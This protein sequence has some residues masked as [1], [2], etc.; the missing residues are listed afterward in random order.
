MAFELGVA[1]H[2]YD[3]RTA[4]RPVLERLAVAADDS[5]FLSL[6]SGDES[7]CIDL[8]PGPSPIRVVTLEIGTRRPLGAGAGGL[9]ILGA[10]PADER[11]DIL[12]R[13]APLLEQSWGLGKAALLASI[14]TFDEEGHAFIRNRVHAGIS[15][16]G[17]PVRGGFGQPIAAL[18]IAALNER[19]TAAR[20]PPLLAELRQAA[21][22]LQLQLD[23][24]P[25]RMP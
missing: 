3:L 18:S 20:I 19:L 22:A 11:A 8:Q 14:H 17:V 4:S 24:L 25:R 1:A 16:I 9:A 7:V 12:E 6:R 21:H 2:P 10:L 23:R 13:V 15:A 5:V